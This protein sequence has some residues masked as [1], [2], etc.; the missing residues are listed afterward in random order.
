ML[1]ENAMEMRLRKISFFITA[2]CL[3]RMGLKG[4]GHKLIF[5][6]HHYLKAQKTGDK[7]SLSKI[8]NKLVQFFG[9]KM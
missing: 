4:F 5:L 9:S 2:I 7:N 3:T 1:P 8:Y 6:N